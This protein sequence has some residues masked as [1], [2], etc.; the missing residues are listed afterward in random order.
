MAEQT[1]EK[2][3][4]LVKVLADVNVVPQG[5][6]Q[7][8]IVVCVMPDPNVLIGERES[9]AVIGLD[10]S[11]SIKPWYGGKA[12]P[13][14]T[15]PNQIKPIATRLGEILCGLMKDDKTRFFYWAMGTGG[16]IEDIGTYSS[17]ELPDMSVAGVDK[18]AWGRGTHLLPAIKTVVEGGGGSSSWVMGVILTDGKI[19]DEQECM[20]YC[21]GLG[22]FLVENPEVTIKLILIGV[23]EAVNREQLVRFDDMFEGTDLED[24]V[25][26]WSCCPIDDIED[27]EGIL[28]VLFGELMTE[29]MIVA[30]SGKVLDP[31]GNMVKQFSDGLPGKFSFML[32]EDCSSFTLQAGGEDHVQDLSDA[33]ARLARKR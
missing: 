20:E 5:D 18:T 23:G 21:M 26:I 11:R 2:A 28:G 9:R 22:K 6:G 12:G 1:G 8:K 19:E 7:N 25:D 16:D 14:E 32:P 33:L 3:R 24:D 27:E 31:D 4:K 13:F 30:S 10:A 17:S 29:D 15:L